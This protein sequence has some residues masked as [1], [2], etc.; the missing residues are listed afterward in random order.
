M[1]ILFVHG[2]FP[3][4]YARIVSYLKDFKHIDMRSGSLSTNQ[5][6]PIIERIDYTPHREARKDI[7]PALRFTEGSVIR[8]QAA[9]TAFLPLKKSGWSPDIILAHSGRG[10]GLFMKDLWPQ[11]KYM[12]YFEW[13][14]HSYGSDVSFLKHDAPQKR[15]TEIQIRMKNTGMLQ[16]LAAM[17]WGQCPTEYQKSQFPPHLSDCISV[18]HDGVDTDYFSPDETARFSIGEHTFRKGDPLVT[19]IARGMEPY[20]GFPQFMEAVAILQKT[21]P[22]VHVV[23]FGEDRVA[24]GTPRDDGKT[25]KEW[26]LENLTLD[27]SRIHFAGNQPIRMLRDALRVSAAHVYLTVPFVLSWSMMEAMSAGALL[28]GSD[29]PPVREMITDGENGLLVPFFEPETLAQRLAAVL[30]DPSKYAPLRE[31]AR[32]LMLERYD[33][34]DLSKQYLS[35]IERVATGEMSV[36]LKR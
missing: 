19:Y 17:D 5:R 4:Q 9:L 8:G 23:I 31:R 10:D 14:Y 1:Q 35:L 26:A 18:L 12:P 27:S 2:N 24:Y 7:H 32:S 25:Y 34:K 28:V 6:R 21:D 13:Y 3:G 16:D 36:G 22:E 20:R 33:F 30:A 11:A 29:T 15:D